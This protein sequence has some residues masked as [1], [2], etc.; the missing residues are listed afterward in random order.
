M[1]VQLFTDIQKEF[2]FFP[3]QDLERFKNRFLN[4][5]LIIHS[6]NILQ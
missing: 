2:Q 5:E 6:L 1:K 4:S 3:E